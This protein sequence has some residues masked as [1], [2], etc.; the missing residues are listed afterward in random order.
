MTAK[1]VISIVLIIVLNLGIITAAEMPSDFAV[2]SVYASGIDG[3]FD[4]YKQ[5]DTVSLENDGTIGIPVDLSVYYSADEKSSPGYNGTA[6]ILYVI[7]TMAERTGT[8]SDDEIIRSMLER[9]YIVTVADY[10]NNIR[11]V[12]PQLDKS[13]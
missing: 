12:S 7:N 11:A 3:S 6:V 4:K 9:G 5:G 2:T 1:R 8:D 13:V 10:K